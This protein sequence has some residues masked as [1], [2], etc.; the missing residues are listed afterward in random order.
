MPTP[1]TGNQ[2]GV[3]TGDPSTIS[4]SERRTLV[5]LF[6]HPLA[7]NLAWSDVVALFDKIGTVEQKSNAEFVFHVGTKNHTLRRPHTDHLTTQEVM[8]LRH[9]AV[10]TGWSPESPVPPAKHPEPG[11]P[12]LLITVEHH[13]ARVY[14]IDVAA[15]EPAGHVIRPYDPHH[16]L[17][18]LTH[19]DQSRER[20]QRSHED[21]TFYERIAQAVAAGG[22]IVLVGHGK[23]KSNA[24]H[25]LAEYL[26]AHHPD[27]YR[28]VVREV[29]V[30]LSAVTAPQLLE[31]GR[32]AL[33]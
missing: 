14:E 5:G 11:P 10:Q 8:G 23:G 16:F 6:S 12:D 13:E 21:A 33:V 3:Q 17:H 28:R 31:V 29:E 7:H 15:D 30:D 32:S 9:F 19:K 27:T 26:E 4:R 18:H 22:R 20:G 2:G 24:T 1:A 25:H